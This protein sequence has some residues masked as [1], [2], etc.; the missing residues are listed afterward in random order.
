M[1]RD[2]KHIHEAQKHRIRIR[3]KGAKYIPGTVTLQVLGTGAP[4]SPACVYIFTDQSRYLFNCGEGT[5]RLAHEHKTKLARLEHIF[6]TQTTWR[7]IGGLPGLSLTIQD[8]GVPEVTLHGPPGLEEIFQA[9]KRFVVLRELKVKAIQCEPGYFYE[10]NVMRVEYLPLIPKNRPKIEEDED[11]PEALSIDDTDYYAHEKESGQNATKSASPDSAGGRV[12]QKPV[13]KY[14]V[15][16]ICKLKPRP[17][18]LCL[19]KCVDK[20]VPPG[21]LLGQLKNGIDV[22]LPNGEV[23]KASDVRG[24]DDMGPLF[25]FIDIPDEEYL[26]VLLEKKEIFE[27][28]QASARIEDEQAA[29]VVHFTPSQIAER[30]E[31]RDFMD[32]FSPST[33]HIILND[34]NNSSGNISVHRIQW[35][36]NQL[37]DLVFPILAEK[38]A[39]ENTTPSMACYSL[40]PRKGY[41]TSLESKITREEYIEEVFKVPGFSEALTVLKNQ[42]SDYLARARE[43]RHNQFPKF[44]FLGTGSCI[45]NK[46]RNVS[47]ILVQTSKDGSILLDCGEGSLGQILRFYG[48][49]K[50]REILRSLQAIYISHLHA[51]H[52]IGLIGILR[53]RRRCFEV[54]REE[55]KLMLLAPQQISSWLSFYNHQID[56]ISDDFVLIPN[57]Q[58]LTNPLESNAL[59]EMGIGRVTTCFVPHCPHSFGVALDLTNGVKITY[60]GDT[61][62][63]KDLI[64]IG[65]NS[66]VLIHEATMED[67]LQHEA[68]AKMHSTVAQA[69]DQGK[70]M[71]AQYTILTHFSQRYA[72]LPRIETLEENVGI[73]FDNMEVTVEDMKHLAVMHEPLKLMFAEHCEEME[74]KALKRAYKKQRLNSRNSSPVQRS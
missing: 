24:P 57:S 25:I 62:P 35:Q 56:A 17:G 34:K 47:A 29:V 23:V 67:E 11:W 60:S 28:Y 30:P 66:T 50:G 43:T 49:E 20:G 36:L 42:Q 10:D 54:F 3:E 59:T 38:D 72:K 74:Q 12:R 55:D 44:L 14:V 70:A 68:L 16:Y 31:Y 18:M 33:K 7:H 6:M 22:T 48:T 19:E 9:M 41:D 13:E 45:P 32:K 73:A 69:I 37:N 71:N 27:R 40:R 64:G 15:A 58:M 39:L 2:V 46:T 1:P 53:A 52:H 26:E 5:Q 51:D 65:L 4:G 8:S 21:P 63:S 61:R